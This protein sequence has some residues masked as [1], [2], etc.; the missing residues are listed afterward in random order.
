MC[1]VNAYIISFIYS[2]VVNS[3]QTRRG[4]AENSLARQN[5]TES[6]VRQKRNK[7]G[8]RGRFSWSKAAKKRVNAAKKRVNAGQQK[9]LIRNHKISSLFS[10]YH[11]FF[12]VKMKK[13]GKK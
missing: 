4:A 12:T 13:K 8:F 6:R 3:G 1:V 10:V 5:A 7:T 9:N 2:S 11:P